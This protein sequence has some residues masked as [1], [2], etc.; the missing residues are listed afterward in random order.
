LHSAKKK[1]GLFLE[2]VNAW[3]L[4]CQLVKLANQL[5]K[6]KKGRKTK[7]GLKWHYRLEST[8]ISLSSLITFWA[9]KKLVIKVNTL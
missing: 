1:A 8:I 3:I 6:S 7:D 5:A 2:K 4:R 9:K